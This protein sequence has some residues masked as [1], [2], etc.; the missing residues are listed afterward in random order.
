[1]LDIQIRPEVQVGAE[2]LD[3]VEPD[4]WTRI[5]PASLKMQDGCTC[6]VGQVFER[7]H[8]ESLEGFAKRLP[9]QALIYSWRF[10]FNL[11]PRSEG[12][13]QSSWDRLRDEWVAAAKLRANT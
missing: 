11:E 3:R 13:P 2:F 12:Y 7:R 4:W 1:M 8:S 10:G 6:V 5:D 9:Y